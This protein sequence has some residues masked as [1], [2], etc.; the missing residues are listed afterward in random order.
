MRE[1]Q[2]WE[3]FVPRGMK[4]DTVASF[5]RPL[6]S[7]P[8]VG[9]L[10]RTP[11]IVIEQW[12]IDS[13]TRFFM[14]IDVPLS[15]SFAR[16]QADSIPGLVVRQVDDIERPRIVH[17]ADIS[18][19][20]AA[21]SLRTDNA[22]EVSR[23]VGS[24]LSRSAKKHA[25]VLQWIIGP[26]QQRQVKPAELSVAEQLG[27]TQR[28]TPSTL[29][30]SQWRKK[31]SEPLF[32]VRGR[33]GTTAEAVALSGL[34]RAVQLADSAEG[35][36]HVGRATLA[37]A[38][39]LNSLRTRSW[40]GILS[41][42]ELAVLLA[43][44]IDG[45]DRAL[46][47]G[48]PVPPTSPSDGRPLGSSLHPASMD[49]P[50]MFPTA[51]IPTGLLVIGPTGSGKSNLLAA[52]ALADIAAGRGV[53]VVEPKGDLCDAIMERLDPAALERVIAIDA[54]E[55][56]HPV[57]SN[58]LAGDPVDAE[59]RADDIVSMFHH[60]HG[61]ALGPRSSDVLLH[62]V[63]IAARMPGG[64]LID[65]PTL[66]TNASFRRRMGSQVSDPLILAP[67]LAWFDTLS[68]A[69]RG[70]VVAP[71]LNKLR[72]FTARSSIRRILGQSNPGW[73]WD[74]ALNN[75]GIVLVS[76][77]RGVIGA[78]AASLLGSL[79]LGS[80]L[81]GALQRR[82]RIAEP[83]R[84][85]ASII[86]DEW[87]LFTGGLDFGDVLATIRGAGQAGLSLA[88]QN[89]AQLSPDLRA[90]VAANA[91]SKITFKPSMDDAK[92]LA[93]WIDSPNVGSEDLRRLDQYEAVASIHTNAGT[94]HLKTHP[95]PR[96]RIAAS[97]VRERSRQRFGQ[98]GNA[99]DAELLAKWQSPEP[100]AG[101]GRMKRGQ[102]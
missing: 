60:I 23:A 86:V 16:Q 78:E 98:S 74:T 47:I 80:Q 102:S 14:G 52:V 82:S 1:L 3:L 65:V 31:A 49:A 76:L 59:R 27:L 71:I 66:L 17:A 101:I 84:R 46:P 75:G 45:T 94:T 63:L 4:I 48:D 10:R 91:R 33:I 32:A 7:R 18:L 39:A 6:A 9:I 95:L 79:I 29:D 36:L 73:D 43:F 58:V 15:A 85:V 92:T 77:N 26:A 51:A 81:W 69:E 20:S 70:Q 72:G 88:N 34:R 30:T 53:V 96:R 37:S 83:E 24:A 55:T 56:T 100:D 99:V 54:G 97:A 38:D 28:R 35:H 50:V 41:A 90:A 21:A 13:T 5:V 42:S 68:D 89:L 12:Q 67:W 19:R 40:G 93:S 57:G 22:V 87:Q 62:A 8:R 64:T 44:P 2:W 11:M 61:T 25:L